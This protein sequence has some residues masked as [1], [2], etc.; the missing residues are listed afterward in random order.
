VAIVGSAYVEINAV[1]DGVADSI[2][3]AMRRG[4]ESAGPQGRAAGQEYAE[5]FND[6]V[7]SSLG[8]V[9]LPDIG[10]G[11]GSRRRSGSD[12]GEEWG[13]YFARGLGNAI[14]AIKPI[15][16][17]IGTLAMGD[18]V[19]SSIGP[20][21]GLVG[22]LG[23]GVFAMG[24]QVAH[25]TAALFALAGAAG[26]AAGAAG[27]IP[28]VFGAVKQAMGVTK[29]ATA[30]LA[31]AISATASGAEDAAEKMAAL[32]PAAQAFARE[33][34]SLKPKLD[35]LRQTAAAGL[36][37]GVSEG[38]KAILPMFPMVN[39]VVGDTATILGTLAQRAGELVAGPLAGPLTTLLTGNVSLI[40]KMG[41]A[42]LN[43]G[44]ILV[45]VAAAAMPMTQVMGTD[46]VNATSR[47]LNI[48]TE[49][50]N[51]G[52]LDLYFTRAYNTLKLLLSILGNVGG[53]LFST[54][55]AGI[56]TGNQMLAS[57][58]QVTQ[59]WQTWASSFEGQNTLREY[60]ASAWQTLQLLGSVLANVIVVFNNL[61]KAARPAGTALMTSLDG[62]T[63]R[64]REFT[65][66][67]E[68]QNRLKEFFDA[69]VPAVQEFGRLLSAVGMMVV[70]FAQLP[71]NDQL[72]A[73]IR[74]ELLPAVERLFTAFQQ[75][76]LLS[77]FIG[78]LTNMADTMA[79]FAGATGSASGIIDI[80]NTAL[81]GLNAA[82]QIPGVGTLL[83]IVT[84]TAGASYALTMLIG[85]VKGLGVA[86]AGMS[87]VF[88]G[89]GLLF[90]RTGLQAITLNA[91]MAIWVATSSLVAAKTALVAGAQWAWN[92]ALT[93]NPIGMAVAAIALLVLGMTYLYQNSET[94]RVSLQKAFS[95]ITNAARAVGDFFS[96]TFPNAMTAGFDAVVGFFTGTLPAAFNSVVGWFQNLPGLI[97]AHLSSLGTF[98]AAQAST[99]WNSLVTSA[100]EAGTATLDFVQNLPFMI[101]S[102]LGSL[103]GTLLRLA[104]DGWAGFQ[105]GVVT[106]AVATVT[107]FTE[108]PARITAGLVS[109]VTS[110]RDTGVSA[111]TSFKESI[112]A[113]AIAV[114]TWFQELPGRVT[115]AL[116][117]LASYLVSSAQSAGSAFLQAVTTAFMNTVS[118]FQALPARIG[119]FLVGLASVLVGSA[120]T[121]WDGFTTGLVTAFVST[122]AWFQGIP[123]RV[124]GFF[125]DAGSW[126]TSAGSDILSGLIQ[127][128]VSGIAAVHD[129]FSRLVDS[130]L[131]GFKD[132]L[133]IASPSTVFAQF[134]TW[135]LEGLINGLNAMVA[136]VVS[137]VTGVGDAIVAGFTAFVG[138]IET[139]WN[140]FWNG[141][142]SV[143]FG[144]F[145]PIRVIIET[146]ILAIQLVFQGFV[147]LISGDWDA[148]WAYINAAASV[149]LG[150]ISALWNAAWDGIK[151]V[152]TTIWNAIS[153]A[154]QAWL[155]AAQTLWTTVWNAVSTLFQT[156]WTNIQTVATTVWNAIQ[157][158]FTSWLSA[159]QT[160]WSTV[161]S[162]ISTLFSTVWAA[163]QNAATSIWNAIQAFLTSGLSGFQTFWNSIWNAISTLFSSIWNAIQAAAQTIWNAI[164][165]F[166]QSGLNA[167]NAFW[168]TTWNTI[169][170]AFSTIWNAIRTA[171]STIWGQIQSFF[172]SALNTF[173]SGWDT[174]WG[175]IATGFSRIWEGIKATADSAWQAINTMF[176]SGIN[177]VIDGV[178]WPINKINGALGISI[179]TIP[180]LATG[181]DAADSLAGRVN[182]IGGRTAD[183]VPALLSF[184][185][186]VWSAREVRGAGGHE[187]VRKLREAARTGNL[188][189]F[190]EGGQVQRKFIPQFEPGAFIV[191][192][193]VASV[194][195]NFLDAL[196]RGQT[197][198][199]QATGGRYATGPTRHALGGNIEIPGFAAGGA[200]AAAQNFARAQNGK[201][202]IWGGVGPAG[203]D[204]SG[205]QSAITNVLRGQN[206][207][208]RIGATATFPWGGFTPG[209]TSAYS[210]GSYNGNP[211]HMA[212]TL[213]GVNVEAGGSPSRTKFGTGASGADHAR[214][215]K[216]YSLPE[217]GGVFAGGGAGGFF[218]PGALFDAAASMLGLP[219]ASRNFVRQIMPDNPAWMDPMGVAFHDKGWDGMRAAA[220]KLLTSISTLGGLLGGGGAPIA[221]TGPVQDQVRSVA[222][223]F[224]WDSGAEWNA[225]SALIHKESS[226]DPNA[227]NSQSSARG[228][229]QKMTSL[230]GPV[231]GSA[232][233]QA[234]WGL[235]YIR[236]RYGS[237]SAALAHHNRVGSYDTGGWLKPGITQAINGTGKPEAIIA[238]PMTTFERSFKNVFKWFAPECRE[239]IEDSW[240]GATGWI[241]DLIDRFSPRER[242]S[243]EHA[244]RPPAPVIPPV[245]IPPVVVPQIP[246]GALGISFEQ[247]LSR[248]AP[249]LGFA[250]E[251]G[252]STQIAEFAGAI[253]GNDARMA[254]ISE[255]MGVPVADLKAVLTKLVASVAPKP[256]PVQ[257]SP[258]PVNPLEAQLKTA[259]DKL[260]AFGQDIDP[261]SKGPGYWDSDDII[262]ELAKKAGMS[263]EEYRRKNP[264][265]ND[266][267]NPIRE[268]EKNIDRALDKLSPQLESAFYKA[269]PDIDKAL[270]SS[271]ADLRNVMSNRANDIL[272]FV[273]KLSAQDAQALLGALGA[274]SPTTATTV[275]SD[276]Q[277]TVGTTSAPVT[278]PQVTI[279]EGAVQLNINGNADSA[280]IEQINAVLQSSFTEFAE[281]INRQ[282]T[283][284][285]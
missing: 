168:S 197:E 166:L 75:T 251:A 273:S 112:T 157:T 261:N 132:S 269:F 263:E 280:T 84:Y 169:S 250:I 73:Q 145:D 174:F 66:S 265:M 115:A 22:Q 38:I 11:S 262:R 264:T 238:D 58:D 196:N 139:L 191:N 219:E 17:P 241:R 212:G 183:R 282:Y 176:R 200:I 24:S 77:D 277:R 231:E 248:F 15:K 244:P 284:R 178:N 18:V 56:E 106:A 247:A 159:L 72:L 95:D 195:G 234:Q 91:Q 175:N 45:R 123:G 122:V 92:A 270:D 3:D 252:A 1:T 103:A 54:F 8:S 87:L 222:S 79:N 185:E 98:I 61:S 99:A 202:Y 224:G 260:F 13:S 235:N 64:W 48:V 97:G 14:G 7:S 274:T 136:G 117:S 30:G 194:A 275:L 40:Q 213:G 71:G 225:L 226:W 267:I 60:F 12:A 105:N 177:L 151:I 221:A 283:G 192:D 4:A 62:V 47:W 44:N 165:A 49:L 70:H 114:V 116:V 279:G 227:A 162:A 144:L 41:D 148:F 271:A 256:L 245:E 110:L 229:F 39:K 131:Q 23:A 239:A 167:F 74:T 69:T 65:G 81:A 43:L 88:N 135:I 228:L 217:V 102:A 150:V 104:I 259:V 215:T 141:L 89:L 37:P 27:A 93:A 34:L 46:L 246:T 230:H 142:N 258:R 35:Q 6:S 137:V 208:S 186:H 161:W 125:V 101:A 143:T 171:A 19:A 107:F 164:V 82:L 172:T 232:G 130:F 180:R 128:L 223:Q 124:I 96:T 100:Q 51:S 21:I 255:A 278:G 268:M 249:E 155:T 67:V 127:G 83:L 154:F 179:P 42:G 193:K 190:A 257:P 85:V 118:W 94:I 240:R 109:L 55:S 281:E 50:I 188:P 108:L 68:G 184:D 120:T 156:I 272:A 182:G 189:G 28:V 119:A 218:D 126:L 76:G 146:I 201:P 181:G 254:A 140:A 16:L 266:D 10:G 187:G 9:G 198:A 285:T 20:L 242:P 52:Q 63:Q 129:F 29:L 243:T 133:G 216:K 204:C 111:G 236:G 152:A 220:I 26:Q 163:I 210:V 86:T 53:A 160:L 233:G 138:F 121:A 59:K 173:K 147:A 205:F 113:A 237:P 33:V 57:L 158:F 199:L 153:T 206:P 31:E 209:L 80:L 276:T 207:H 2:R 203:Y 32:P 78:L 211:G 25:G 36:F 90:T 149:A 170:T 214:F 5:G 253:Q 134:G